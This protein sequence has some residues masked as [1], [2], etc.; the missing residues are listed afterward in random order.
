MQLKLLQKYIMGKEKHQELLKIIKKP[1]ITDKT[2]GFLE[3]NW[4]C[5]YVNHKVNKSQIKQAIEYIFGVKV[6]KINTC[7]MPRK[8]RTVGRFKGYKSHYKKAIIKLSAIDKINLFSE[9]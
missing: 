8:K 9:Q 5:F 4:Y 2:T 3:N 7:H 1:I 6:I